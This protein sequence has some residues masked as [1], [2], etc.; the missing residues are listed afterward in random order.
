MVNVCDGIFGG[1]EE[2]FDIWFL[3]GSSDDV[4]YFYIF[5]LPG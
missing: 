2:G 4:G 1:G 5:D 3:I